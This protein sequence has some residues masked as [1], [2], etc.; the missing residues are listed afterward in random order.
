MKLVN[1]KNWAVIL[2]IAIILAVIIYLM[3]NLCGG[4]SSERWMRL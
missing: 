4:M 3:V 2:M 1:R